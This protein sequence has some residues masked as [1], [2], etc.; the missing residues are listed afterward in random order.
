MKKKKEIL[1][2]KLTVLIPGKEKEFL[3]FMGMNEDSFKD[4]SKLSMD[5]LLKSFIEFEE[6]NSG[7]E[8][9]EEILDEILEMYIGEEDGGGF[10]GDGVF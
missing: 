8:I 4:W 9:D 5:E 10:L 6:E 7:E 2:K 1:L 3:E